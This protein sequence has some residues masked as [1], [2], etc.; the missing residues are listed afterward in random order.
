MANNRR[1]FLQML[2]ALPLATALPALAD[3]EM[4]AI[5][6]RGRLSFA[7]YEK[8]QPYSDAGKGIDIDLAKALAGKLGLRP[9]IISFKAGEDMSDD[10]RNMVW[11]GH[12]LRGEAADVMM[13][14]PVD[15]ILAKANDKVHIFGTYHQETMA[16]ARIASRV[17]V[18]SGS[19]AVALEVFTREKIGVE[20]DT[21]ADSFLL[22]VLRGR[23]RDNVVHFHSVEEAAKALG[24]G[25]IS[26]VLSPR[27][28]LEGALRGDQRFAID[29]VKMAELSLK[30]WPLGM[31]VKA[32]A[33]DLVAALTR[34]LAE[35][36]QDG[37]LAAIFKRHQITWREA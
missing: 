14:V 5:R 29:E 27:G 7:V 36:K 19:A 26:A 34:A 11:K 37:S 13:H 35:L 22:S 31:A 23:L 21:L 30:Q 18:P 6:Q 10:L 25:A 28:E 12:Y 2:A 24:E 3:E 33:V 32:E 15:E 4:D 8:F 9:E 20:G 16:M 1:H 17:P